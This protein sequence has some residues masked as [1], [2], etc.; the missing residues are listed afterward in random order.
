M[1]Y[2]ILAELPELPE[3]TD[4][5]PGQELSVVDREISTAVL[6]APDFSLAFPDK[7]FDETLNAVQLKAQLTLP[8]V[9]VLGG[10]RPVLDASLP[11]LRKPD[12]V[13]LMQDVEAVQAVMPELPAVGGLAIRKGAATLRLGLEPWQ[14]TLANTDRSPVASIALPGMAGIGFDVTRLVIDAS[15]VT[16]CEAVLVPGRASIGGLALQISEGSAVVRGTQLEARLQ[17]RFELEYFRGAGVDLQLA[18][19]VNLDEKDTWSIT[20]L[21]RVSNN[22][23]WRDPSGML[24]FDQ[25]A[26]TVGF[27]RADA[28]ADAAVRIGG[29]VTFL[30]QQL[31]AD[32]DAWFGKLFSGLV[33][34]FEN[35]P[36]QLGNIGPAA[37]SFSPPE[38]LRL[39]AFG[40][41]DMRVPRLAFDKSSVS[42]LDSTLRFEAGGAV[43]SGNVGGIRVRLEGGPTIDFGAGKP[44][45]AIEL[46]A[47][48]GFKGQA[49][50]E[51]VDGANVQALRGY[52]RI[53]SPALAPVEATFQIGRFRRGEEESWQPAVSVMAAQEDVNVAL[54][55]GVVA[56]RVELGAGINRRVAGV[57]GLSLADGQRRLQQGL[58]NVFQQESWED[59][60]TDLCVVARIF[61]EP[62]QTHGDEAMSLYVADMT[63]L[64]TSDLQFAAFGKLWFYTSRVDAKSA[65]FQKLPSAIGL[66]MFDGRQPSLRVVAMTRP[67]GR[68][69]LSDS[70]PAGQ[71][72]GMQIPRSQLALEAAPS[73]MALALGPVEVGT[74]LGPLR[75]AGSSS[76]ALRSAGGRVYA[77]SRSSLSAAFSASTGSLSIGPA[78]L[79]GSVSAS[80]AASLA[81]LGNFEGGRLTLYGLAHACCSVEL[82]LHVRIGFE[83]RVSVLF[84]SFTISWHE[85][86]DFGMGMHV[87][88]DLE[89]ALSSDGGIGIDGRAQIAVSVLGISASLSLH[90]AIGG[91]HVERGR[92]VYRSAVDD[93]NTLLGVPA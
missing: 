31:A 92:V 64:M 30:P 28:G 43:V 41:F 53:S 86:W 70:I 77:L 88:L 62:S 23:P 63:L 68:S 76:F 89:A 6:V 90:I 51:Q 34:T 21:T 10:V 48:G 78:T 22:I 60:D 91:E 16:D 54:F 38:A 71:L 7:A 85:D 2:K 20:G 93:V 17:A 5:F 75:V 36:L 27:T 61:T 35:I 84:G 37:F 55:P 83:I 69:S 40:I 33:A 26:V 67:D 8:P 73:G 45:I 72:M 47:P 50:L 87:D 3:L 65:G 14:L 58:P 80:F 44:S 56:T 57:T 1:T 39:R 82:A 52:G 29:R 9:A 4:L 74:T 15:G 19:S 81:L 24:S 13:Y 79:S 49:R 11:L 66:A 12:A 18:V 32:A 42:L 46:A 25:M 59:T